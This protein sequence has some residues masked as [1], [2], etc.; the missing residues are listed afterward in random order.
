[1]NARGNHISEI[2]LELRKGNFAASVK[3]NASEKLLRL[4]LGDW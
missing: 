1:M 3:V 2:S 4:Q